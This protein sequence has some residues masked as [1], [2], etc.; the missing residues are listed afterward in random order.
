MWYIFLVAAIAGLVGGSGMIHN[1]PHNANVWIA[2][3]IGSGIA[4]FVIGVKL[5]RGQRYY[6][7]TTYDP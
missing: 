4:L 3:A 7:S 2:V 6:D 5:R 1:D